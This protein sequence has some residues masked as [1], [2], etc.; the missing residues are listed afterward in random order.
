MIDRGQLTDMP[1]SARLFFGLL[2]IAASIYAIG[3]GIFGLLGVV[4]TWGYHWLT[5]GRF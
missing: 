1:E 2:A 3:T 5:G 4:D